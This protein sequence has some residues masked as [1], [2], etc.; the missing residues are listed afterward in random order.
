MNWCVFDDVTYY[1]KFE[2]LANAAVIVKCLE[3]VDSVSK[4]KSKL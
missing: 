1:G 4:F 3:S 2:T